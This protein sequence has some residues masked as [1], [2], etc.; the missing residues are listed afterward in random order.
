MQRS[1]K[2]GL[3]NIFHFKQIFV[4]KIMCFAFSATNRVKTE[5][6]VNNEAGIAVTLYATLAISES[7]MKSGVPN[8]STSI[9]TAKSKRKKLFWKVKI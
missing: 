4:T 6:L 8:G 3:V 2:C 7:D 9:I 5:R 1:I